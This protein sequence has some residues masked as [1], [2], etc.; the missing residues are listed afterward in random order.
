MKLSIIIINY[1]ASH[2]INQTIKSVLNSKI[3]C[4]YEIII[5]D[6]NSYDNSVELIEKEFPDLN[7][8]KNTTNLGFSKGVNIGVQVSNATSVLILNPDT[9]VEE[10]AI[11]NMYNTLNSS[12]QIS[13]VG[14]KIIDP[15]GKFQLSSRRAYPTF[16]T[17]LFQVTG[18]SYLFPRSKIFGR[19]NYT[20]LSKNNSASPQNKYNNRLF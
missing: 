10:N 2:F 4:D 18:L 9:I 3:N 11:Q 14:A 15:D 8:I 7:I 19:Y 12:N 1:K 17:S 6:N 5:V 16:L 20:Y 13:V